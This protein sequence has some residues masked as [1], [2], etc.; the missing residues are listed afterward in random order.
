MAELPCGQNGGDRR[1][2]RRRARRGGRRNPVRCRPDRVLVDQ[3]RQGGGRL[4]L[5]ERFE[6]SR[7]VVDMS[8]LPP[9][10]VA[11]D[12]QIPEAT[13]LQQQVDQEQSAAAF[14]RRGRG[15]PS[16]GP[17]RDRSPGHRVAE[18]PLGVRHEICFAG[19][20]NRVG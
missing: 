3:R 18:R 19:L 17:D 9:F 2:G 10:E 15:D 13:H 1:G 20:A 14:E 16:Q 8:L 5:A 11:E 6:P 12:M 7:R 4:E